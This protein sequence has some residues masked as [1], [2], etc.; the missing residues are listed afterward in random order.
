MR[1]G[2]RQRRHRSPGNVELNL[3]AM[4]DMAFQ[5]LAFFILTFKPSPVE[6]QLALNMPP[7]VPMTQ[8]DQAPAAGEGSDATEA[9]ETLP[10]FVNADASGGVSQ[11]KVGGVTV[12]TGALDDAAVARLDQHLK[13]VTGEAALFERM[14]VS[15]DGGLQYGALMRILDVCHRQKGSDGKP[16]EDVSI[17][18]T[19]EVR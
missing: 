14:Q 10:L 9:F 11:I 12:V 17:V 6:G 3:A 2:H 15:A 16:I 18:E 7:P 1:K 5:L 8:V 13:T 19:G 4:L